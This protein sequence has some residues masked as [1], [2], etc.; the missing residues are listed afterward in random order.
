MVVCL[1]R[2]HLEI[3]RCTSIEILISVVLEKNNL[4]YSV[5]NSLGIFVDFILKGSFVSP[6]DEVWRENAILTLVFSL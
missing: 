2:V 6:K 4:I 1:I 3:L 5:T